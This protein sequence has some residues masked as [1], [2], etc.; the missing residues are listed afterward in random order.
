MSVAMTGC[1]EKRAKA[2]AAAPTAWGMLNFWSM[3]SFFNYMLP[4]FLIVKSSPSVLLELIVI[5]DLPNLIL[6]SVDMSLAMVGLNWVANMLL[7]STFIVGILERGVVEELAICWNSF[8]D[9]TDPTWVKLLLAW[10]DGIIHVYPPELTIGVAYY[11]ILEPRVI[12]VFG[13]F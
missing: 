11:P 4:L 3:W 6:A 5:L 13:A 8:R 9:W 1:A 7:W 12:P 10:T 2:T